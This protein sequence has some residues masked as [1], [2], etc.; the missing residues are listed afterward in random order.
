MS[1]ISINNFRFSERNLMR[2]LK[3]IK[4]SVYVWIMFFEK[5][6]LCYCCIKS[7]MTNC[8]LSRK[9]SCSVWRICFSTERSG[10]LWSS[11][12]HFWASTPS[13]RN[14]LDISTSPTPSAGIPAIEPW[15]TCSWVPQWIWKIVF[16]RFSIACLP[17]NWCLTVRTFLREYLPWDFRTNNA[18]LQ[19]QVPNSTG[20]IGH[21][22]S[23][24]FVGEW[25]T[26][27]MQTD[28]NIWFHY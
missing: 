1:W 3:K 9:E 27:S 26:W 13:M 6:N 25:G 10:H 17:S 5:W 21:W 14:G 28:Y 4:T 24:L 7:S 2:H 18:I 15:Y 23:F 12:S 19:W 11:T 8:K 16:T 20:I 22:Y